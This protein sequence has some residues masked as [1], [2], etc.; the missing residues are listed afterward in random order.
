[1]NTEESIGSNANINAK[2]NMGVDQESVEISPAEH[3][4]FIAV[5]LFMLALIIIN[6]LWIVFDSL[7]ASSTVQAMLS[8]WMPSFFKFYKDTLHADFF[9][10]DMIFVSIFLTE[11]F[12]RWGVAIVN[13][14][15]HRWFFYPFIHWYDVLGCIPVGSFRFLRLL[16]LVS[17]IYRLQKVGIIDITSAYAYR[18]VQKYFMIL[19][20]EV[21]DRV[22]VNV[23]NG[24]QSEIKEGTPVAYRITREVLLPRK[25]QLI[26]W[27]SQRLTEL[28]EKS[29]EE[30]RGE[31]S[32]YLDDLVTEAVNRNTDLSKISRIPLVGYRLSGTLENVVSELIMSILDQII[33]DIKSD[34]STGIM[35]EIGDVFVD[36]IA[37]PKSEFNV[38]VKNSILESI[39]LIKEE[40]SVQKWKT[41][42]VI[43]Q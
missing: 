32:E 13:K 31:V 21:S 14:T 15:Y 40:V 8:D 43:G 39:E 42:V 22:V 35:H 7:F 38:E 29:Y 25:S 28:A 18:F 34:N 12:V 33:V 3:S 20:E 9:L 26:E 17:I 23:L 1:M 24:V 6:L 36:S 19:V 5:D 41:Q 4:A 16:R 2:D 30:R 27:I 10:Y 11:L 37:E